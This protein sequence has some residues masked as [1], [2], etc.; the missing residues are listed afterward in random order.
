MCIVLVSTQH[1]RYPLIILNNRDEFL[2]RATARASLWDTP[3]TAHI[4]SGRDLARPERGTWL[5]VTQQGRI[6]ILTNFRESSTA[7]AIGTRSRGAMVNAF[8]TAPDTSIRSVKEWVHHLLTADGDEGCK[9]VG[10]FSLICGT[11]R[12]KRGATDNGERIQL[13]PL[14]VISN[15]MQKAGEAN[16]THWICSKPDQVYALSNDPFESPR[17]WPK[18]MLGKDLMRQAVEK[19]IKEESSEDEMIEA[20]F[21]VL[22]HDTI[23]KIPGRQ[24]YDTDLESLRHSVFIPAFD[25]HKESQ[26][27]SIPNENCA[28]QSTTPPISIPPP[29]RNHEVHQICAT[30]TN[31]DFPSD[32]HP[33][34]GVPFD[35]PRVYGTQN[36]TIIL[37]DRAG[38]LKYI[39]RTLYNDKAEWVGGVENEDRDIVYEFQIEGWVP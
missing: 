33:P 12:P 23:P 22:S 37:V 27:S 20:F 13:E 32:L 3:E 2:H 21:G 8:L 18:V 34:N 31:S 14:A 35:S 19:A 1:P 28:T 7:A 29:I 15:R 36:Q 11:I 9:N 39:E 10:G 4:F 17:P 30:P 16:E 38:R 6:T 25:V 24:T 5:G 26:Q